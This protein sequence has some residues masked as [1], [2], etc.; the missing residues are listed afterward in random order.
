MHA[1]TEN[2]KTTPATTAEV[3]PYKVADMSLAE[4]GSWVAGC[5]GGA[6]GTGR[7]AAMLYQC[8]GSSDSGN[9]NLVVIVSLRVDCGFVQDAAYQARVAPI[10]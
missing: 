6:M 5:S 8:V 3:P 1:S 7:S 9:R 4:M 10:A 2:P